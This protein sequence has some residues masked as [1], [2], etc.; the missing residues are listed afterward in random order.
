MTAEKIDVRGPTDVLMARHAARSL[1]RKI[2]FRDLQIDEIEIVVMELCSN[3]LKY[4]GGGHLSIEWIEGT[5][6]KGIRIQAADKGPGIANV[7][8]ALTKGYSTSGTLGTG[9]PV[10]LDL[11][12][13]F[14]IVTQPDVGTTIVVEK[15][16]NDGPRWPVAF[17]AG[18]GRVPG[19]SQVRKL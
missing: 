13:R 10:V 6:N 18:P 17:L 19:A 5:G 16:V 14:D 12:N 1:A 8:L 2:P 7:A 4:A 11:V 15:W 3:L 9:L